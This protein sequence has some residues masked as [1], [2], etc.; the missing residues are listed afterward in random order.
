MKKVFFLAFC[1]LVNA[2]LVVKAQ[3]SLGIDTTGY[4]YNSNTSFNSTDMY[5]VNIMNYGPQPYSGDV[6][7]EYAVDSTASGASLVSLLTDS[8]NVTNLGMLGTFPDSITLTIDSRFRSGINTVVIWPRMGSTPFTTHDSL[9]LQVLVT[10]SFGISN[11]ELLISQK[12]FPNPAKQEIFIANTDPKFE[13]ERVRIFNPEGKL[14]KDEP[15]KGKTDVS[16]L[17][18]GTYFIEFLGKDGKS[19]RHKLI[20]E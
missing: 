7:V 9:K 13:I 15:F 1:L 3:S 19:S 18:A 12:L 6:F 4:S 2:S 14:Q 20:K 5:A 10:G 17:S 11:P 8:L 16:A